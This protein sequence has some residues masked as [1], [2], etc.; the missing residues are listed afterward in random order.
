[1]SDKSR[2]PAWSKHSFS[3]QM[4]T[5]NSVINLAVVQHEPCILLWSISLSHSIVPGGALFLFLESPFLPVLLKR[6]L[7]TPFMLELKLFL[8]LMLLL[9]GDDLADVIGEMGFSE[10]GI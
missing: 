6:L 4:T 3:S 9:L 8:C 2:E 5:T 7:N 1:M 10:S